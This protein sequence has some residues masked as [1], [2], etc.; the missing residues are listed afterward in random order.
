MAGMVAKRVSDERVFPPK[1]RRWTAAAI[2]N[3]VVISRKIDQR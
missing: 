2:P 1:D 3:G